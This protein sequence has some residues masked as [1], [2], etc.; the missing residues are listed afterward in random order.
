MG[1]CYNIYKH[2]TKKILIVVVLAA[3][4]VAAWFVYKSL[5]KGAEPLSSEVA[6]GLN[7]SEVSFEGKVLILG[8]DYVTVRAGRVQRTDQGNMLVEYD[9]V[10]FFTD[11]ARK[12]SLAKLKAGDTATFYGTGADNPAGKDE[13]VANRVEVLKR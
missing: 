13:F 5:R 12:A 2:M 4:V 11:A 6:A 8:K 3:V 7:L 1:L 10:V 9:K